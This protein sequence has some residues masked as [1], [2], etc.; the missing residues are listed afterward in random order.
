MDTLSSGR[1][2]EHQPQ[3]HLPPIPSTWQRSR[4]NFSGKSPT[5]SQVTSGLAVALPAQA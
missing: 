4:L 5:T 3:I 2:V 1:E